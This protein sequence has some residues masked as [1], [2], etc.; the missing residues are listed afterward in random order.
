MADLLDEVFESDI[1]KGAF[2]TQGVIGTLAGPHT[3]GTAYVMAHHY[4]G[5]L[6]DGAGV[7]GYVKGGMGAVTAALARSAES[8]GAVIRVDAEVARI[9]TRAGRAVGVELA[10]GGMIECDAVFSNADPKRTFLGLIDRG[11]LP[12][13]FVQDVENIRIDG[14]VIKINCAL[15]ELPDYVAL[16]GVGP[17]PQHT[18]TVDICPSLG[19]LDS[20]FRDAE[21]GEP[22]S[23][24]FMEVY[25][26]SATDGNLA[27]PGMHSMSIF[28]QYA[29]YHL[30]SGD[31]E[32]RREE[33]ADNVIDTLAEYAPNVKRAIVHRQVLSP[34]DLERRFG[35]TG[36]NIFHGEILP[37]QLF[38]DRPL[39]GWSDYE[40]PLKG[41][42]LCGSGAHPGGGV[43]GAPGYNAAAR[44][45]AR[46]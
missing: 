21:A 23:R 42:Y 22:S 26:Q 18:G 44:Y 14:S 15:S 28:A 6:F 40:T 32:N 30:A 10:D 46:G 31:W 20:A 25:I 2:A 37:G 36:G 1:V 27:P 12:Q 17:G 9:K 41:L 43:T 13:E 5:G 3:P 11:V 24:P 35:L 16:P 33:V 7:W 45:L 38:S 34:V 8:A 29:P 4:M 19:Y 39:P